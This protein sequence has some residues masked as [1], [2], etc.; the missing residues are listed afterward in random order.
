MKL[1]KGVDAA[2]AAQLFEAYVHIDGH[3][4]YSNSFRIQYHNLH[5]LVFLTNSYLILM[6]E[7]WTS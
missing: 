7:I 2:D 3:F 4:E 1:R 5:N 6:Y